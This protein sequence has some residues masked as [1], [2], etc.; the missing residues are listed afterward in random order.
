MRTKYFSK[1]D[2]VHLIND[3]S[4]ATSSQFVFKSS[5]Q[6]CNLEFLDYVSVSLHVH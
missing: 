3:T 5:L 1:S 4:E 6:T 2:H